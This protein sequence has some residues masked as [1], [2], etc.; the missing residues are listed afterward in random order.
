MKEIMHIKGHGADDLDIDIYV[1]Q[2]GY[3]TT[4]SY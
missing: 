2:Q 4:F 1:I 3:W